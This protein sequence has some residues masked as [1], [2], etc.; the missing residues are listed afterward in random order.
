MFRDLKE[1]QE[2]AK[3]YA[4][5][6]SKPENLEERRGSSPEQL[7][8]NRKDAFKG[9]PNSASNKRAE[10]SKARRGDK[11]FVFNKP[12]SASNKRA[13]MS[14]S[15]REMQ[16]KPSN[17]DASGKVIPSTA[18]IR[19]KA[20][21]KVGGGN[22]G[23]STDSGG[24]SKSTI[25]SV[26]VE[27]K[28]PEP[29]TK[30]EKFDKKFIRTKGGKI[31]RRGSPSAVRAE[32]KE[33]QKLKMKDAAAKRKA[34]GKTISDVKAENQASMK[35]KAAERFAAFKAKRAAKKEAKMNEDITPYD[36]VLEYLLSS[37]QAAT[38]EEANYVM[39][40]MDAETIQGIVEE[41]KKNLDE[42]DMMKMPVV[43]VLGGIAGAVGGTVAAAKY[44][45]RKAGERAIKKEGEKPGK[46]G[47]VKTMK[48]RT[49]ATNKAIEKM[50]NP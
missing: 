1:Y 44:L 11:K 34:E 43:N 45:G 24:T 15:R 7:A 2:I 48:D 40:E 14:N 36:I 3:I 6:V 27:K 25:K 35:A 37:E 19:A 17:T 41:Q 28:K 18:E 23:A 20:G 13:E 22:A 16:N 9:V 50:N 21:N 4:D 26:P 38:I 32:F 30:R 33:K 29:L 12:N 47:L 42:M 49:D 8:Q 10:M 46:P 31:A 5:K 39:T